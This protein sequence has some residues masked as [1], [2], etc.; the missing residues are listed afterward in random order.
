M[1]DPSYFFRNVKPV[2]EADDLTIVN[3]EG[4]LT[5]EETRADKLYAFK[6]DPEYAKI[7]TEGDVE[8]VKSG[9]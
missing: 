7:L 8:A 2:F 3:M 9:K 6:A 5:Q 1:Q 4:T